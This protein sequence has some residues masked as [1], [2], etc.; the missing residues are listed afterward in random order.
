MDFSVSA[1]RRS[2]IGWPR[3]SASSTSR[4]APRRRRLPPRF[5]ETP[6]VVAGRKRSFGPAQ[7]RMRRDYYEVRG[8]DAE[9]SRSP[10]SSRT[11]ASA[12]R[13]EGVM[14]RRPGPWA[15]NPGL[16][17]SIAGPPSLR[18]PDSHS[19]NMAVKIRDATA[20]HDLITATGSQKAISIQPD[21]LSLGTDTDYAITRPPLKPTSTSA[22]WPFRRRPSMHA[23]TKERR[24][25]DGRPAQPAQPGF[26]AHRSARTP[27]PGDHVHV[28]GSPCPAA[29][30]RWPPI[31][32]RLEDHPATVIQ[33]TALRPG[34]HADRAFFLSV[35]TT[36]APCSVP[37][38]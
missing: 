2:R 33:A 20:R 27:A 31:P 24:S 9:G 6:I 23:H 10:P 29:R 14:T 12:A 26:R 34:P 8:W 7:E 22:S 36:P 4:R 3:W 16:F 30:R 28:T 32:K 19:G 15:R 13:P 25:H 17:R 21:L 1:S 11:C 37:E 38:N 35:A 18:Y 5:A